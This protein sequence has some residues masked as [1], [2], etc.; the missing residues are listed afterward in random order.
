MEELKELTLEF[1]RK[2]YLDK[3]ESFF[4][5]YQEPCSL[6]VSSESATFCAT[7]TLNHLKVLTGKMF[8]SYNF[9]DESTIDGEARDYI[10]NG[11]CNVKI[12]KN[13]GHAMPKNAGDTS[14]VAPPCF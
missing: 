14:I 1:D 10:T 3:H 2:G 7:S 11:G 6:K 13:D 4:L 5:E 9:N 12:K 8:K